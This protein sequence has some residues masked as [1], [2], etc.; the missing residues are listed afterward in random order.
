MKHMIP[1][2]RKY[3]AQILLAFFFLFAGVILD[4]MLPAIV[5]RV[6]DNGV[7]EN[8]ITTVIRLGFVML[9]VTVVGAGFAIGRCIIS[10]RVSQQFGADLRLDL[11]AY[12]NKFS[13][14]ALGSKETAGL[15]TRMTN[16]TSQLVSFTN[17]LMRIFLRAPAILVGAIVLTV[18]LNPRL[19]IV[20]IGVVPIIAILMYISLKVTFP[21]FT[22]MQTALDKN[23]SVIREYL[24]GVRVVKAYNTFDQEVERFDMSNTN[25]AMVSIKAQRTVGI[26]FP[27]ISFAVNMGLVVT[28]WLA[29]GWIYDSTM[30]VGQI[31]AF[32]NYMMQISLA[33]RMIFNVYQ[34]F[35]RAK[36]S[37]VRVGEILEEDVGDSTT[38]H[39]VLNHCKSMEHQCGGQPEGTRLSQDGDIFQN[40]M[41]LNNCIRFK[42]VTFTYPGGSNPVLTDISFDLPAREMLGILGSTGSGKTSLVQLIPAFY[43]PDRGCVMVGG[44]PTTELDTDVLRS[45]IA[46]VAQQN[47]IFYGT[48]ADNIR[49]GKADA[50]LEELEAAARK[51]GAYDF[52][53]ANPAGF[54]TIVGQKGVNLSGGQ[55]QRIGIARALVRNAPILIL[56]DCVSAVDVETEAGIMNAIMNDAATCIVITQRVSTV[57]NLK[58]I[59]VLDNGKVAGL[60][61]HQQLMETCEIYKEMFAVKYS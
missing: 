25:L 55:K 30:Q 18:L 50:T 9:G 37:A 10:S 42:N 44:K 26:F 31:V 33:L 5:S 34:M 27:I 22:K 28:L 7:M 21:L 56:D 41:T 57:M 16:D 2:W 23:N 8:D 14:A 24:S 3:Q 39:P 1:Y 20:L 29:R 32:L 40:S 12:I 52:I 61:D 38:H 35:I 6:I 48:I 46:Y 11:F 58:H 15:I 51:A 4:L 60:G 43:T 54:D 19:A 47:T 53:M 45:S 17:S 13:F 59:L 49:M 36:A